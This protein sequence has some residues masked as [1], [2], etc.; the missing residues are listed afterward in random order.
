MANNAR[1]FAI[2]AHDEQ[3]YGDR[4]YSYH[5]DM[6]AAYLA[7]YGKDVLIIGYLH[8]VIEDTSSDRG[9][10]ESEFGPLV[11][12]CVTILTDEPG[13]SRAERKAKI[14][15]KLAKVPGRA[16]LALIVKAADR[17]A[18]VQA[19][20]D[21]DKQSLLATYRNEHPTF[22]N[23]A[24]RSGLCDPFWFQLDNLLGEDVRSSP[25]PGEGHTSAIA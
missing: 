21:D 5:L 18:N 22:R 8:D 17:L 23:A 20:I 4:P 10:I 12:E 13:S 9:Q 6:V 14:Y 19:C 3:M 25:D 7:P 15:A 16:E 2:N 11:A 24:Y 1:I